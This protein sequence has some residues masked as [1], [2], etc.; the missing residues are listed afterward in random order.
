MG[1]EH[2]PRPHRRSGLGE[3]QAV[4]EHGPTDAFES[5]EPG[6]PLVEVKDLGELAYGLEGAH[7][8]D[9]EYDLLADAFLRAT[10]VEPVADQSV[11]VVVLVDVGVEQVQRDASDAGLPQGGVHPHAG[12]LDAHPHVGYFGQGHRTRVESREALLLPSPPVEV[13]TEIAV[14]VE[15]SDTR[16][17]QAEV[18]GRLQVVA[19]QHAQAARVLRQGGSDAELRREV[20]HRAQPIRMGRLELGLE[21]PGRV[22]REPQL[23]ADAGCE[24]RERG[25]G[26]QGVEAFLRLGRQSKGGVASFELPAG[27]MD[28][29]NQV[30]GPFVVAPPQVHRHLA[31]RLE[32]CGQVGDHG[33]R[34]DGLHGRNLTQW[35]SRRAR[36]HPAQGQ[37]S[38]GRNSRWP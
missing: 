26:G 1:R 7:A 13:L 36:D 33:E 28:A 25:V 11:L 10:A 22:E 19:G 38:S 15:E 9:A 17:R 23:V 21:P 6:V 8:A 35:P 4:V 27:A 34:L 18:V 16:E 31:E 2:G 32:R 14:S 20:A 30:D 3:R 5:E 37:S 29:A 24:R 12:Q